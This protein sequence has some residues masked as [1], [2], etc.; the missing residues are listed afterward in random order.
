MALHIERAGGVVNVQ[1]TWSDRFGNHSNNEMVMA[2]LAK[3]SSTAVRTALNALLDWA[4]AYELV[5]AGQLD[6]Y[7]TAREAEREV[8]KLQL[9]I[10][11]LRAG[12]K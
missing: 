1:M 9:R 10:S 11:E 5:L 8:E 12:G 7:E 3:P 6:R 4:D 2:E